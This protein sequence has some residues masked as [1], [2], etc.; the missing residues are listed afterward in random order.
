[1]NITKAAVLGAGTMGAGIAAHLSNAGI[2][3]L[4][5]DIAPRELTPDDE[6]KGLTLDSPLVRNR[7][8]DSLFA[9]AKKLK[10]APFMLGDNAKL[11]T[12]GNFADDLA[13]IKDCDLVIEAVVENL[14]IKHK[15]FADVDRYRKPGAVIAS[16][17]SGI[18][19]DSIAEPFSDDFKAHFV[20]IHFFNPPRYMKLVEVIPGTKTSGEVA[21]G[22]TGFVERGGTRGKHRFDICRNCLTFF[23]HPLDRFSHA[24]RIPSLKN[25]DLPAESPF[26]SVVDL[27]DRIGDL[28]NTVRRIT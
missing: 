23:L 8:V 27:N 4:L 2:P 24:D 25:T 12:T 22:I 19:I 16:N 5:L 26:D 9:A 21:C 3:T 28:R 1:M 13:K 10:P 11:I 6:K 17:T 7:I 15:L 20:G 14:E 18:P